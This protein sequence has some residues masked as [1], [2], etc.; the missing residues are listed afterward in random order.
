M[1]ICKVC[2]EIV[3]MDQACSREGCPG[4]SD[5]GIGSV[6]VIEPGFSGNADS[7]VQAGLDYVGYVARDASRRV[8][9]ITSIIVTVLL[10]AGAVGYKLIASTASDE[11]ITVEISGR[12]NLRDA[13]KAQGSNV[14]ETLPPGAE[15]TGRWVNGSSDPSERWLEFERGGK[16][17]YVWDGNLS[18]VPS[19]NYKSNVIAWPNI[20][21]A[22]KIAFPNGSIVKTKL[23][24]LR[25][26]P[27][28]LIEVDDRL[29][30]ISEGKNSADCH[31]CSGAL[32]IHYLERGAEGFYVVKSWLSEVGLGSWGGAASDW[33]ISTEFV[34][35]PVL[36]YEEGYTNTGTSNTYAMIVPLLRDGIG[37]KTS[38]T[39]YFTNKLGLGNMNSGL[40]AIEYEAKIGSIKF[41]ESF[42]LYFKCEYEGVNYSGKYDYKWE[43]RGFVLGTLE[44]DLKDP[45]WGM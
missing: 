45:C 40:K 31:A 34:P 26:H 18:G 41:G 35:A 25:Y 32:S 7:A 16:N 39:T 3:A 5:L 21:E 38:V 10:I 30:L 17:A 12:A 44:R 28:R 36:Y 33:H 9:L 14:I 22:F 42:S 2:N 24:S 27:N 15:L 37:K 11:L 13:P 29:V 6:P 4:L 1:K 20:Q 19:V 8:A 43:G 23:G